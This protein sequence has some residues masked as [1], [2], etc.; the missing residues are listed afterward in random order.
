MCAFSLVELSIVLVILGLLTGGVLTGHSDTFALDY[1][2]YLQFGA[3]KTDDN[4]APALKPEEAWNIDT[5]LDDG[6][7]ATGKVIA[8]RWSPCTNATA[9]VDYAASYK[10]TSSTIECVLMFRNVL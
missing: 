7:P 6:K 10:L 4:Y 9:G 5:K 3:Q 1:G 2:N 8:R